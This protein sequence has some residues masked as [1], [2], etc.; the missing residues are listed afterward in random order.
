METV[1]HLR[2]LR[3][4]GEGGMGVVYEAVDERLGR[5]VA[6]KS[7]R[8]DS[9]LGER[10]KSRFLR[11]ARLLSRVDHPN[12][13]RL[14]ELVE[15]DTNDYLVLEL[16]EGRTLEEAIAEGLEAGDRWRIAG[17]VAAALVAAHALS[18][19]HR[20]LKPDN[21][22]ITAEG[23]VKVLDFGLARALDTAEDA[24]ESGS[25]G[26]EPYTSGPPADATLTRFGDVMGTPRYMSPE[27]ARG[28]T[29]TA[30][31][32]MYSFGLVLQA[33]FTGREPYPPGLSAEILLQKAMWGDVEPLQGLDSDLGA[34]LG[35]LTSL[36]PAER[37]SATE[38]A[39]RLRWIRSRPRR[40]LRRLLV[41]ALIAVLAGATAVSTLGFRKARR[42]QLQAEASE[43]QAR[44]A[45]SQAEAV[46][47]F[48]QGMLESADPE[49]LG[50]DV[51]VIDVLD[52][53]RMDLDDRF[54][55]H[56]RSKASILATLGRTYRTLGEFPPAHD[57][58]GEAYELWREL[59][60]E[61][62]PETLA[63]LDGVGATLYDLGE[64]ERAEAILTRAHL[65]RRDLLGADHS[66]TLS[67]Q[68]ALAVVVRQVR[69]VEE[70]ER[71][72]ADAVEK[73]R[74]TLGEGHPDTLAAAQALA[75]SWVDLD[76]WDEAE[77]L[78][79]Q[80]IEKARAALGE[81]HPTTIQSLHSLGLV[82]DRQ[83]RF[84]DSSVS[85]E[86]P[87]SFGIECSVRSIR[88][89]CSR[90]RISP[91]AWAGRVA[92]PRRKSSLAQPSSS[93]GGSWAMGILG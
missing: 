64:L 51:R 34:L 20:D 26:A 29:V 31:S 16:V 47:A 54:G 86:R 58:L 92:T 87:W 93:N 9:R 70:A 39:D 57:C 55:D 12:I 46:N 41:A 60:G 3:R 38:T 59:E 17:Q 19:V 5:R 72:F 27:Q 33:L 69:R 4:L 77:A 1:G 24:G 56:P 88:E 21:I 8:R 32:D 62:S 36:T 14:L 25:P 91:S 90:G 74:S 18:V 71:L 11:E 6:V 49:R 66:D 68:V 43:Q 84:A 79:R 7:L 89:R 13:C 40:R 30:A 2:I 73:Y 37:P 76:R 82:F 35:R 22:M 81:D 83:G 48:L 15:G 45:Q 67:S 28:E 52:R 85:G 75:T 50:I 44:R 23:E 10:A 53:A 61:L 65:G 80:V 42:A 78:L 63:A